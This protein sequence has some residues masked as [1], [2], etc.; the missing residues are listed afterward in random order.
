MLPTLKATLAEL[1]AQQ[2]AGLAQPLPNDKQA[3]EARKRAAKRLTSE[4]E[5]AKQ[6]LAAAEKKQA[7][8]EESPELKAL[9]LAH[10]RI[11]VAAREETA[12]L[13]AGDGVNLA[14]WKLFMPTCLAALNAMYARLGV[15]FDLALGESFYQP[16]LAEVV[17]S[18]Q[19]RHRGRE[20]RGDVRV[21][22]G[23]RSAVHRPQ[24]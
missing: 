4:V 19:A 15:R 22:S 1:L 6:A 13:H 17:E 12:K 18:L 11:A 5:E 8:V 16:F 2:Q 21:H 24:E 10:P 20:R 9:A 7:A 23:G 3:Q 14:L